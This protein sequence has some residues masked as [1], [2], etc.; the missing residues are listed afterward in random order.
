MLNILGLKE[1]GLNV[2]AQMELPQK[3]PDI[4]I[5]APKERGLKEL[6]L[7]IF[8]IKGSMTKDPTLIE[9]RV[10]HIRNQN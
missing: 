9:I 7:Q 3:E 1:L 5:F 10:K 4:N 2:S 6:G 8:T